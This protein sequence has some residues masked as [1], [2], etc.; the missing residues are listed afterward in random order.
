MGERL[1]QLNSSNNALTSCKSLVSKPSVNQLEISATSYYASDSD[2]KRA[3]RR[4]AR[5]LITFSDTVYGR[6]DPLRSVP[7]IDF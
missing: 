4:A 7:L 6:S 1:L 3:D 2:G 5:L